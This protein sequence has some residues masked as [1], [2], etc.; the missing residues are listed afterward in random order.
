MLSEKFGHVFDKPLGNIV[1]NIPFNPNTLTI[2]G[3]LITLVASYILIHDLFIGGIIIIA[4]GLFDILD[5]L[6]ARVNKKGSRFGA[7]LDSV[8]DRYS[9]AFILLAI[10]WNLD[11]N[12]NHLGALLCLITL[13][14]T[15]L[16]SYSRA[17]AEG[18]GEN[19]N[20]GLMERTERIILI[21]IGTITGFIIPVLWI[22]VILTHFTVFQRVYYVWKLTSEKTVNT[23]RTNKVL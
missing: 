20:Q 10:A 4:G 5:G 7:F 17:R 14:G 21:S 22:L 1:K 6:V 13:I 2:T 12:G 16:I 15:F 8:L 3:F 9:D 18:L 19:C 11:R 23:Q